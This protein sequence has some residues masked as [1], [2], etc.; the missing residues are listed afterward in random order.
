MKETPIVRVNHESGENSVASHIAPSVES[1]WQSVRYTSQ[2]PELQRDRS[3]KGPFIRRVLTAGNSS[4]Y[5]EI[6]MIFHVEIRMLV[7]RTRSIANVAAFHQSE[8][9][10]GS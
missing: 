2:G 6:L 9:G 10:R 8:S 5:S 7:L 3:V 4:T 1:V